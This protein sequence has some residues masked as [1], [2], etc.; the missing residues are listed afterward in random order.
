MFKIICCQTL[1]CRIPKK[2]RNE[3]LPYEAPLEDPEGPGEGLRAFLEGQGKAKG[4]F[5]GIFRVICCRTLP[6][7]IP[8]KKRNEKLPYEAPLGDLEGP[9]EGLRAFLEGQG[10]AKR[11]FWEDF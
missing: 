8:K 10:K 11:H 2:K 9:G 4:H 1:P 5:G 3:K 6:C 7:R